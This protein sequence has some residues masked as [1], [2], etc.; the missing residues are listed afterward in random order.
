MEF[1]SLTDSFRGQKFH[2]CTDKTLFLHPI[3]VKLI[4]DIHCGIV[5]LPKAKL[6]PSPFYSPEWV[7]LF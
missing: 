4:L 1:T 3:S 5:L 2:I 6:Y 7:A